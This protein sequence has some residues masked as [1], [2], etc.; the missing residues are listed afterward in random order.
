MSEYIFDAPGPE[1]SFSL[2]NLF[3]KSNVLLLLNASGMAFEGS[4]E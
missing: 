1:F 3:I 4:A 2:S